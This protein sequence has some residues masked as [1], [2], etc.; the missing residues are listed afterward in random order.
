MTIRGLSVINGAHMLYKILS[1]VR[2]G[3][4]LDPNIPTLEL[5]ADFARIGM[6]ALR[7]GVWSIF[8][9]RANFLFL[10]K[11]CRFSFMRGSRIGKFVKI[12]DYCIINGLG[13]EGLAIGDYSSIGAFS[14]IVCTSGYAKRGVGINIGRRVGIAEYSSLG[15]SGGIVIGDNTI[16][17][18]YFSAHPENHIV[19]DPAV[20]IRDQGTARGGI[21][22]GKNCWIGAKVTILAGVSIG[23]G[24][25]VGAGAV[26]TR[27]VPRNSIVVGNP[28]KVIKERK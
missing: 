2:P 12:G 11:G 19:S 1:K 24:V 22:I 17:A 16:I 4:K 28:A 9:G 23:D 7:G 27:D 25:V 18:Q 3:S 8:N 10:G 20:P 13:E 6:S 15:G 5:V 14:R 26:V 21:T